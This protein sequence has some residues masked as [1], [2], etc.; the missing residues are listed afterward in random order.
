M[1]TDKHAEA[2]RNEEKLAWSR[3]EAM[4]LGM[5][6]MVTRIE[7]QIAWK[8]YRDAVENSVRYQVHL[9]Q[10]QNEPETT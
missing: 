8:R 1:S 10:T 9:E 5:H 7:Y 2:C 6:G 4:Y 3:I